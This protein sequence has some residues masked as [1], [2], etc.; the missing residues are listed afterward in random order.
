MKV[1]LTGATGYIGSAVLEALVRHGHE[2]TALVRDA[3][4]L[5]ASG[6]GTVH[7]VVADLGDTRAWAGSVGGHEAFIHTA[8][9]SSARGVET[10][11]GAIATLLEGAAKAAAPR[12][13]PVV[14]Y[15]S[16][17]WVLG[18]TLQPA[19]EE[20]LLQPTPMVAFRPGHEALVLAANGKKVR[21]A[22][23]RPGIV[24][25]GSR[26]IVGDFFKDATNGLV[27]VI[28][29]GQNH[30]PFVYDRD[31]ADLYV[32][33]ATQPKVSGV[34]HANDEGDE[35]V[36]DVVEAITAHMSSRPDIRHVPI[37]EARTKWGAYADAIVLDQVVRSHRSRAMGWAPTLKNVAENI[38]RL[39]EEWRSGQQEQS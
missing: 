11:R 4:R 5:R 21:T 29:S 24:V 28:G 18:N 30:W 37:E 17:V 10:D 3:S 12:R 19:D 31:L 35:R 25:G 36:I 7:P 16:G 27:R 1:F 22:V 26:G 33:I 9:D 13:K 23:V 39:Y 38:P 34:F 32:R 20:S 2:V 6:V 15:T 8:F 14:I